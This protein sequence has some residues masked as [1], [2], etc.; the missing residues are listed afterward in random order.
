MGCKKWKFEDDQ[1][2]KK[3]NGTAEEKTEV[4]DEV[5]ELEANIDGEMGDGGEESVIEKEQDTNQADD[6]GLV[7]L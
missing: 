7:G 5:E 4:V 3:S 2:L 6:E 1:T